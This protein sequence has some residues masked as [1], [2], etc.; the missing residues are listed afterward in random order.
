MVSSRLRTVRRLGLGLGLGVV[1]GWT[2]GLLQKAPTPTIPL[3]AGSAGPAPVDAAPDGAETP[4]VTLAEG[5]YR[6]DVPARAGQQVDAPDDVTSVVD[7]TAATDRPPAAVPAQPESP[8]TAQV[9]AAAALR[10]AR[11]RARQR[12]TGE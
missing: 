11:A 9:D 3:A 2:L 8:A 1:G 4:S 12:L 10:E 7:T 5:D 6:E